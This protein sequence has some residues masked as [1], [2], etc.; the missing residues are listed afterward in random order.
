M[1]RR[2]SAGLVDA[3]EVAALAW[4]EHA[5]LHMLEDFVDPACDL[6]TD[7]ARLAGVRPPAMRD[8]ARLNRARTVGR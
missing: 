5:R 2:D 3:D 7:H 1:R 4:V 6:C 8:R